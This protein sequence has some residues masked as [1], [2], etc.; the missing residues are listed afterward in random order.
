M[1][2]SGVAESQITFV[3]A[4]QTEQ[5][6]VENTAKKITIRKV[7]QKADGTVD[8]GSHND[9]TVTLTRTDKATGQVD[10]SWSKEITLSSGNNW[11]YIYPDT[12][13]TV[14]P[15]DPLDDNYTYAVKEDNVPSGYNVSYTDRNGN[16]THTGFTSGD[17]VVIKN[18]QKSGWLKVEKKWLAENGK[19]ALTDLPEDTAITLKLYEVDGE[20]NPVDTKTLKR[21]TA[22]TGSGRSPG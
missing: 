13:K 6:Y 17:T 15:D 21:T 12:S 18:M 1:Q 9:I 10:A 22:A 2:G 11:T 8:T 14:E 7:W 16:E 20:A 3:A 5:M 4:N 19:A